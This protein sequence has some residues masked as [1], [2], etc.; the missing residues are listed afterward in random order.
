MSNWLMRMNAQVPEA[1]YSPWPGLRSHGQ[2]NRVVAWTTML[3]RRAIHL[4]AFAGL[5]PVRVALA[6]HQRAHRIDGQGPSW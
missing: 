1:R 5:A 3:L 2:H 4:G 6:A